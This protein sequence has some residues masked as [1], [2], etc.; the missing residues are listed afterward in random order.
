MSD[1]LI[2]NL[3]AETVA[4]LKQRA[5]RHN[6]SLQAE[7]KLLLVQAA[8]CEDVSAMLASWEQRLA[9]REFANSVDLLR[10]DRDR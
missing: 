4:R 9:G 5:K 2:R 3:D 10:E 7:A 8:G 1:I 6:R